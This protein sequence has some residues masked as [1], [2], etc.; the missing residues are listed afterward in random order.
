[1]VAP[2]AVTLEEVTELIIGGV[3]SEFADTNTF[4]EALI[5]GCEVHAAVTTY[6]PGTAGATYNPVFEIEPPVVDQV[7]VSLIPV[8]TAVNCTVLPVVVLTFA[9]RI[10][11]TE[12]IFTANISALLMSD[13]VSTNE[14][15]TSRG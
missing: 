5:F 11:I 2:L 1:M 9:G 8:T 10:D 13:I 6:D 12:P 4:A 7:M 15:L 3:L 14:A